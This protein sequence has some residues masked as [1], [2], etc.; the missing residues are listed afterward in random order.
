MVNLLKG[1][2]MTKHIVNVT[3]HLIGRYSFDHLFASV[4]DTETFLNLVFHHLVA[5]EYRECSGS[6]LGHTIEELQADEVPQ[7]LTIRHTVGG[8]YIGMLRELTAR[9]LAHTIRDR[10]S[11]Q[12]VLAKEFRYSRKPVS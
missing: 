3:N 1:D 7:D 4:G 11:P 6:A 9:L 8:N 2:K 5:V 12:S 10:L